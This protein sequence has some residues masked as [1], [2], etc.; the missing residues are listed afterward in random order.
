MSISGLD[1][2]IES[3]SERGKLEAIRYAAIANPMKSEELVKEIDQ[4][5]SKLEEEES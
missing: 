1:E 5:L 4:K 3:M 2:M